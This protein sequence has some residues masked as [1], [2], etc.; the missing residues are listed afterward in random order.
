MLLPALADV[1]KLCLEH[2]RKEESSEHDLFQ[3]TRLMLFRLS[4]TSDDSGRL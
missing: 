1:K 4:H 3:T 2:I